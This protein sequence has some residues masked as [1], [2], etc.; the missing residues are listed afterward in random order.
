MAALVFVLLFLVFAFT[1]LS[2]S[3]AQ[4]PAVRAEA[5]PDEV[6]RLT[7]RVEALERILTDRDWSLR[8]D[9]DGLGQG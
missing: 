7:Q 4:R 5:E 2:M 9:I 8:R 6:D 3:Q 1:M